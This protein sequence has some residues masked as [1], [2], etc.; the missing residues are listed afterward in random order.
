MN[1]MDDK[2]KNTIPAMMQKLDDLY[3]KEKE[4][5]KQMNLLKRDY[6]QLQDDKELLQNM[7]LHQGKKTQRYG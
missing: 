5:I 2:P 7:I 6:K 4:L 1:T 3:I